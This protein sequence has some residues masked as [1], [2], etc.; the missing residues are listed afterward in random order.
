VERCLSLPARMLSLVVNR[1][2]IR[3]ILVHLLA[4]TIDTEGVGSVRLTGQERYNWA[5]VAIQA[6]VRSPRSKLSLATSS[7]IADDDR[8]KVADRLAE[9]VGG[10]V[11]M[12]EAEPSGFVISVTLPSLASTTIL[13]IDDNPD[14]LR[15]LRRYLVNSNYRLL[16]A[17]TSESALHLA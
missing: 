4:L 6:T 5:S 3:Q 7:V 1:S 10:S 11:E 2:A 17:T 15:L 12:H 9:A 8:F 14:F 13:A 16:Q